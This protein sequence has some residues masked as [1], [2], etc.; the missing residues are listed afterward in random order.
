[1]SSIDERHDRRSRKPANNGRRRYSRGNSRRS[2]V[3]QLYQDFRDLIDRMA[4]SHFFRHQVFLVCRHLPVSVKY[5]VDSMI[6]RCCPPPFL[7]RYCSRYCL[8]RRVTV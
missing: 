1:M 5:Q 2:I 4:E 3:E 8:R 7:E 6:V